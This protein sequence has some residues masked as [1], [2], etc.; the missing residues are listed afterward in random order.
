MA[1]KRLCR[2]RIQSRSATT[3]L[4]LEDS[5]NAHETVGVLSLPVEG[6]L[7][8]DECEIFGKDPS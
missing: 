2:A 7:Y 3:G 6:A 8:T 4:M 5:R 1:C